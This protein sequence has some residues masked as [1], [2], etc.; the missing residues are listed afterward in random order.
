[1]RQFAKSAAGVGINA[2][3]VAKAVA[4]ALMARRPKTRYL[5]GRDAKVRAALAK[6]LPDRLRDVLVM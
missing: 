4:H 1:M 3:V 6:A 5:V 2:D